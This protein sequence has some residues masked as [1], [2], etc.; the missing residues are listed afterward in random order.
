[1]LTGVGFKAVCTVCYCSDHLPG[2]PGDAG[3][4]AGSSG[5]PLSMSDD[6]AFGDP[7]CSRFEDGSS[8]LPEQQSAACLG[9]SQGGI[10]GP[11]GD[12]QLFD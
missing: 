3:S 7:F 12:L 8:E 4:S 6:K 9:E 2:V 11:S 1:M 10:R 5:L